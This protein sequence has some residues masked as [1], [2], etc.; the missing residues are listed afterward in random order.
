MGFYYHATVGYGIAIQEDE[1][2]EFFNQFEDFYEDGDFADWYDQNRP[3]NVEFERIPNEPV[4]FLF[5]YLEGTYDS[6]EARSENGLVDLGDVD[7]EGVESLYWLAGTLGVSLD[8]IG[9][10]HI[11]SAN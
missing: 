10:K 5:F 6:G 9:W 7:K 1:L 11:W 8:K 3:W 2:P 4:G